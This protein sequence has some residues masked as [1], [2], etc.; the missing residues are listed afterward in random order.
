MVSKLILKIFNL[1]K[2][3]LAVIS[4]CYLKKHY[5]GKSVEEDV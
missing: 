4:K 2:I 1:I 3:S 5:L